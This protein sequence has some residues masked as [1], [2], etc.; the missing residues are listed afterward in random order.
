MN[1]H[2]AQGNCT[3][4]SGFEIRTAGPDD[5]TALAE[6]ICELARYEGA[7]AASADTGKLRQHLLE[8]PCGVALIAFENHVPCAFATYSEYFVAYSSGKSLYIDSL[9][10]RE[11]FRA[12]G[13]GRR[14]M[15]RIAQEAKKAGAAS[16][17]WACYRWN[18]PAEA[19]YR[20]LGAKMLDWNLWRLLP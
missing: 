4:E 16:V 9:F 14:L 19:F 3:S 11:A 7:D 20:T 8:Q 15:Q 17:E 6:M 5:L 18:E 1:K 2:N 12:R 10:V 13:C